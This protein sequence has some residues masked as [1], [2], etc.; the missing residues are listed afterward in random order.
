[1]ALSDAI[2]YVETETF[3]SYQVPDMITAR[4]YTGETSD[5]STEVGNV[6]Y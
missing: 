2:L 6:R 5:P 4:I 1:M 3:G